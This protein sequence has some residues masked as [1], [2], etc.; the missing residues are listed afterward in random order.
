MLLWD[1]LAEL[2]QG[3]WVRF[4]KMIPR[5]VRPIEPRFMATGAAAL[6]LDLTKRSQFSSRQIMP[7]TPATQS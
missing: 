1:Y 6:T 2:A 5:L 4:V 7:R 3:N